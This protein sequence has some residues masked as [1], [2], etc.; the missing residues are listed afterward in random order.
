MHRRA[1]GFIDIVANYTDAILAEDARAL[2]QSFIS[3]PQDSPPTP[4][5]DEVT[6][7]MEM[8]YVYSAGVLIYPGY[9]N[10]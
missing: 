10:Q 3:E 6:P 9:Y 4:I 5:S 2:L 1:L 8:P 7:I